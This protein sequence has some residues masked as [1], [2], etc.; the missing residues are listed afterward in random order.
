MIPFVQATEE[1]L[2]RAGR[3]PA[4]CT[5]AKA[6]AKA[7]AKSKEQ[8]RKGKENHEMEETNQTEEAEKKRKTRA[9][10]TPSTV[11][12]IDSEA[13][14]APEVHPTPSKL[15]PPKRVRGKAPDPGSEIAQVKEACPMQLHMLVCT[16][17][18]S[19]YIKKHMS[20]SFASVTLQSSYARV[21]F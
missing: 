9:P 2:K 4:L 21:K 11:P 16:T 13:P 17:I 14:S 5:A 8:T 7:S 1:E 20:T 15:V 6:K 3:K 10:P 12:Q 19:G 18:Y